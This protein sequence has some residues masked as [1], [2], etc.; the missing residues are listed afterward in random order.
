MGLKGCKNVT[1][2]RMDRRTKQFV[3]ITPDLLLKRTAGDTNNGC[4][5]ISNIIEIT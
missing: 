2:G 5:N 4:N 1:N 3:L